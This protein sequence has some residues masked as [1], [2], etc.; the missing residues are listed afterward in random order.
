MLTQFQIRQLTAI[1]AQ[2]TFHHFCN[3]LP[4]VADWIADSANEPQ[5]VI[6]VLFYNTLGELTAQR[7]GQRR[8]LQAVTV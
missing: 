5:G 2:P 7:I 4:T 3:P 1:Q 6:T 8:I